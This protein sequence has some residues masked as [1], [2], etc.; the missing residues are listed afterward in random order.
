MARL[1]EVRLYGCVADAPKIT[2]KKD[3]GEYVRGIFHLAVV[4]STRYS[5]ETFGEKDR[6]LYDWPIILSTDKEM[7]S[8]ME[9]MRQYDIVE[10]KGLFVT[11]HI[12][13][14]TFCKNCGE[15][16]R[17][18]GNI[19]FILPLFMERRNKEKEVYTEKQ[20]VQEIIKNREISNGIHIIGNLCNDVT[21]YH[22]AKIQ[23]ASYQIATDRRYFIK[24]DNPDTKAD[25]PIVRS[26]GKQAK[27]DSMCIHTGSAI[28]VD[29]FLHTRE[30]ERTTVCESCGESYTW[31]DNIIEIIPYATEYLANYT[32][33]ETAKQDEKD[34]IAAEGEAAL[35][36]M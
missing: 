25:F 4:R 17:T 5:G 24:D 7:I 34:R 11:R 20:A 12:P 19:C 22:K 3:T 16:N 14:G 6:I 10:I 28:L 13:K 21:Y 32:D 8:K 26:F 30:F 36:N 2:K 33:P 1:N 9:K 23:T 18:E 31:T 27:Q 29:G 35:A 15:R